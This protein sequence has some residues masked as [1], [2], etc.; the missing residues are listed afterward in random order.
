MIPSD[1]YI[2]CSAPA[3]HFVQ[4][5]RSREVLPMCA[6]CADH[7]VKNRGGKIIEPTAETRVV[8]IKDVQESF[9]VF[10]ATPRELAI[11]KPTAETVLISVTA[12]TIQPMAEKYMALTIKGIDDKAGRE[13]VRRAKRDCVKAR[14]TCENEHKAAKADALAECQRIDKSRRDLLAMIAPVEKHLEDQEAAIAQAEAAI[15]QARQDAIYAKRLEALTQIGGTLPEKTVRGMTEDEFAGE[16]DRIREEV[17]LR[18][19]EEQRQADEREA[20]RK[21]RERLDAERAELDRQRQAQEQEAARLRK[22][23][24]DRLIAERA[25]FDRRRA[26][27]ELKATKL[28]LRMR[29]FANCGLYPE[30]ATVEAMSDEEFERERQAAIEK[31]QR[32]VQAQKDRDAALAAQ[33]AELDR[34]RQELEAEQ[35]RLADEAAVKER[36]AEMARLEREAAERARIETEQRL[37]REDEEAARLQA[38]IEASAARRAAMRPDREKLRSVAE[39]VAAICIPPVS[40][41]AQHMVDEVTRILAKVVVDILAAIEN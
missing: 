29:D 19:I 26:E 17:R 18:Q 31:R 30:P 14:T 21:E 13:I 39:E 28:R 15:E 5:R 8:T 24:E 16:L 7:N 3:V 35:R 25:E 2:P 37:R 11:P 32:E 34:Q 23:E 10:P 40:D 38:E 27:E 36:Q 6:G 41:E 20:Q 33:Q 1:K 4:S 9:E 22:V 12:E